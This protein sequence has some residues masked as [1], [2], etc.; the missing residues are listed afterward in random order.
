M[1]R[2]IQDSTNNYPGLIYCMPS[3][4]NNG[5]CPDGYTTDGVSY[6]N[7]TSC[8]RDEV[9]QVCYV[10]PTIQLLYP[11]F[12]FETALL[13]MQQTNRT[14]QLLPVPKWR[15][16]LLQWAAVYNRNFFTILSFVFDNLFFFLKK[17]QLKNE[18]VFFVDLPS[19]Q[20]AADIFNGTNYE[21]PWWSTLTFDF[22]FDIIIQWKFVY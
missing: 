15:R 18:G 1:Q 2:C 10:F 20:N 7:T 8:I 3:E 21:S 19:C 14:N 9:F 11:S 17:K 13:C 6:P 12:S 16:N 22:D 4:L 5:T